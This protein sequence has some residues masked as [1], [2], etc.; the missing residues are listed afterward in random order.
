M[1]LIEYAKPYTQSQGKLIR[2]RYLTFPLES[3]PE[4]KLHETLI[5][6]RHEFLA[7][8][9]IKMKEPNIYKKNNRKVS[10]SYTI[11]T[12]PCF[13]SRNAV[14]ELIEKSLAI[15]YINIEALELSYNEN[16]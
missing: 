3:M 9:D 16:P 14:I 15:H 7:H 4:I 6:L 1:A 11:N 10:P 13:P 8:I 5:N 12:D 2:R